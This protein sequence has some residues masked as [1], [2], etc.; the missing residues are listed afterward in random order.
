MAKPAGRIM[1]IDF[2]MKHIGVALSDEL[3]VIARGYETVNWNGVDDSWAVNRISEIVKEMKVNAIVLGKPTRTDGTRSETE[4]KAEA[5]G[6]K[7][8]E[9][10]GIEPVYKDERFTTVIASRYL[11]DCNMNAKKQKKIIDQV[12]AEIILQ[13]YLDML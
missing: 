4:E 7:I 1:G 12:A 6:E 13:E 3:R 9:A 2:G 10:T 11:H 5:F 8:R